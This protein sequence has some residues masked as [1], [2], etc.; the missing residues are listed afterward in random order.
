M[1]TMIV[2]IREVHVVS[3][4]VSAATVQAG[5]QAAKDGEGE[6]LMVE[7][8]HTLP[9]ESWTVKDKDGNIIE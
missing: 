1:K 2:E 4:K 3:R 6:E 9:S 7:Y 8:S 5:I